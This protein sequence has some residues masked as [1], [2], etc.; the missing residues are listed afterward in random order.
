V[1]VPSST[2]GEVCIRTGWFD[3]VFIRESGLVGRWYG[4]I[5]GGGG[6]GVVGVKWVCRHRGSI[7]FFEDGTDKEFRNVGY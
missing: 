5:R 6:V 1:S 3:P 2:G 7:K 4:P